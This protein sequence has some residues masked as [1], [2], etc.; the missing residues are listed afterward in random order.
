MNPNCVDFLFEKSVA[1]LHWFVFAASLISTNG[2]YLMLCYSLN[3]DDKV[4]L[5]ESRLFS[6][7]IASQYKPSILTQGQ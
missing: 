6:C 3:S 4:L 1:W 5:I 7:S 2:V